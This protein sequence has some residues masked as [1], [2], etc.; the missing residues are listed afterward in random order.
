MNTIKDLTKDEFRDLL[1]DYFAPP[2]KRMKLTADEA[3]TLAQKLNAEINVP[4]VSETKEE[5]ILLKVVIKVDTFLY[6]NLPNEFYDLVRSLDQGIDDQEAER[7]VKRLTSLAND[8]I[9]IPYIPEAGEYVAIK[10]VIGVIVN[11][12]RKHWDFFKASV[13]TESD[14]ILPA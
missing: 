2:E 6:D 12:A 4:L 14:K 9:D 3:K 1:D 11:S 13:A 10:F 8:K 5:K 7:L